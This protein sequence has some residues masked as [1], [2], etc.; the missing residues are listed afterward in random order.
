MTDQKQQESRQETHDRYESVLRAIEHNTGFPDDPY[1][2]GMPESAIL[3]NRCVHA[4]FDP[5]DIE[6]DLNQARKNGDVVRW[7]DREGRYR[8]ALTTVEGL[9]AIVAEE[10][11]REHPSRALL[12][13]VAGRIREVRD[14]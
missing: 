6:T 12:E 5:D 11:V 9:R 14:E 2:A 13:D 7:Q 3:V 1:P 8:Y 10:N 4:D